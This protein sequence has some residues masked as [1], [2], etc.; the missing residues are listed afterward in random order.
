MQ[1][2]NISRL[3]DVP[4]KTIRY[5]ESIGVLP[6]PERKPNGYRTYTIADIERLKLVSGLRKLEFSLDEVSE[7]IA[8]RDRGVAPCGVLLEMLGHKAQ[9]IQQRITELH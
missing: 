7:V 8:M 3:T 5:Y 2:Q 4:R 6:E 1:I 9:E